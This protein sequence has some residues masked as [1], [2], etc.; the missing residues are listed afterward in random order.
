MEGDLYTWASCGQCGWLLGWLEGYEPEDKWCER[1]HEPL[2]LLAPNW[3]NL[4]QV[5]RAE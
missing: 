2:Q 5:V 1:C 4:P 3:R